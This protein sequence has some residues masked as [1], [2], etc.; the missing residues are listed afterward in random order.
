MLLERAFFDAMRHRLDDVLL[1][2]KYDLDYLRVHE[3]LGLHSH[4]IDAVRAFVRDGA[5]PSDAP[6]VWFVP[7]EDRWEGVDRSLCTPFPDEPRVGR[8]PARK[9]LPLRVRVVEGSSAHGNVGTG[10]DLGYEGKRVVV[11]REPFAAAI[12]AHAPS[13]VTLELHVERVEGQVVH[14]G[15]ALND[16]VYADL[17]PGDHPMF[18]GRVEDASG[19]VL[20]DLGMVGVT[21]FASWA[22]AH[23]G[24]GTHRVS[25]ITETTAPRLCHSVWL[26]ENEINDWVGPADSPVR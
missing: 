12:S 8:P 17:R 14:L 3:R 6:S 13:R 25:L 1:L 4:S 23:L 24:P 15:L 16:D 21:C 19:L 22:V 2:H 20:L 7:H 5:L 18:E 11:A 26:F 10:G 9:L